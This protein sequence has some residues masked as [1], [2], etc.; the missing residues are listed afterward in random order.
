MDYKNRVIIFGVIVLICLISVINLAFALTTT[1]VF[2]NPESIAPGETSKIT[3]VIKNNG[4]ND[5]TDVSVGLDFTNLPLAPYNSGSNQVFSDLNVDKTK[6]LEFDVVALNDA[7]SGIYKIPVK[8]KYTEDSISKTLDSMISIMVYSRPIVEVDAEESLLL[9]GQKNKITIK[10]VN[11]G[12][13]DVKFLEVE[14][15]GSTYYSLL[16]PDTVYVGDVDSNDFQTAD[17]NL[18]FN[19]NIPNTINIP[20]TLTYK[21]IT[22]KEYN[23]DYTISLKTYS[24]EQAQKLGLVQKSYTSYIIG[25]VIFLILVFLVYRTLRR[26]KNKNPQY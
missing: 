25:G 26:R 5:L 8:I 15:E 21:D 16:S 22:N 17:F 24:Q 12:L 1:S 11:K 9:K 6:Q 13:A 3:I 10:I 2:M 14:I 20:V 7:K 18:F 4:E 19:K 23:Q